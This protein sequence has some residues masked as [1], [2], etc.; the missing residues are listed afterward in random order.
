MKQVKQ[1]CPGQHHIRTRGA[2]RW[3][4]LAVGVAVLAACGSKRDPVIRATRMADTTWRNRASEGGLEQSLQA[5]LDLTLQYPQDSRVFWRLA[6]VYTL[7][8]DDD[9]DAAVRL[10]GTARE[11]GL[12]CLM[13]EPSFEGVVLSKGGRV[14]PSAAEQLT[15]ESK[16]CLVWT[17]IAW[18]RWVRARGTSGVGLDHDVLAVLGEQAAA[19]GGDWGSGRGHY[20]HGLALSLPPLVLEPDLKGAEAAFQRS[21][22]AAPDRLAPKVDLALFVYRPQGRHA[23]ADA[24]LREVTAFVLDESD[25]E[26]LE[27]QHAQARARLALQQLGPGEKATEA[28]QDKL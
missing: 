14:T 2:F 10:Y 24:L 3:L 28:A 7:M 13:L 17:V 8:G 5:Y 22:T 26:L 1:V 4:G 16:E 23:D 6:R 21:I 20:A 11:Y 19:Y 27:D 18:S 9:P 12:Q 25:T 15:E